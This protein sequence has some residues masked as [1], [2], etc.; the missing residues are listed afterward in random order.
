MVFFGLQ[1][2]LLSAV[3]LIFKGLFLLLALR[4]TMALPIKRV[5]WQIQSYANSLGDVRNIITLASGIRELREVEHALKA[6]QS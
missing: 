6:V 2:L 5:V 1:I 4:Q 3:I